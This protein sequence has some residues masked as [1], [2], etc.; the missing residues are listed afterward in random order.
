MGDSWWFRGCLLS[1]FGARSLKSDFSLVAG[2]LEAVGT[3]KSPKQLTCLGLLFGGSGEIRTHGCRKTS[4]VFKTGAFN[5][6]AT[7]PSPVF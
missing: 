5:R 7:L 4:P 6:S 3:T 1:L 2:M